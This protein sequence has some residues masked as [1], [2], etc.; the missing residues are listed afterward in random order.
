MDVKPAV[1]E[2][3]VEQL[4]LLGFPSGSRYMIAGAVER[5]LQRL[6]TEG[7]IPPALIGNGETERMDAGTFRVAPGSGSKTIGS[8]VA[9]AVHQRLSR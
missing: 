7:R 6:F 5:E 4:V 8:Q 2:L 3:H 1:I 9:H